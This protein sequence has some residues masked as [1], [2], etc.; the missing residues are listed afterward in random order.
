MFDDIEAEQ[1]GTWDTSIAVAV[2]R[3]TTP[4]VGCFLSGSRAILPEG[5]D[6]DVVALADNGRYPDMPWYTSPSYEW[7]D[8]WV[9]YRHGH[10]NLIWCTD[11]DTYYRWKRATDLMVKLHR[12]GSDMSQ[13]VCRV[14]LFDMVVDRAR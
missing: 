8:G 10:T 6:V 1:Y 5:N 3:D 9:S 11:L 4:N 7:E 2:V 12:L 13:R 14:A